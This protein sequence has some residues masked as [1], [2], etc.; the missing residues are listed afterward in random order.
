MF[1]FEHGSDCYRF[2]RRTD[3]SDFVE[4]QGFKND[5]FAFGRMFGDRN[6][7]NKWATAERDAIVKGW[8]DW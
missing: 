6:A 3:T 4:V 8:R 5:E 1:T 2:E 7:A